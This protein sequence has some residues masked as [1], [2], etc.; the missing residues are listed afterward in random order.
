[1]KKKDM[2]EKIRELINRLEHTRKEI[3][4]I[5]KELWDVWHNIERLENGAASE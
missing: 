1:M 3:Q 4:E 5:R 2:K